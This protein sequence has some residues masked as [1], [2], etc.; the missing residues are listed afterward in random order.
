MELKLRVEDA[1]NGINWR[2]AIRCETKKKKNYILFTYS[3]VTPSLMVLNYVQ[4]FS[5][6]I[7]TFFKVTSGV[8]NNIIS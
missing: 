8:V 4:I 3:L 5:I 2:E 6:L 7:N 1:R